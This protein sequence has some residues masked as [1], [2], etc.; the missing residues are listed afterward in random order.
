MALA[1]ELDQWSRRGMRLSL[2]ELAVRPPPK[3]FQLETFVKVVAVVVIAVWTGALIQALVK[4]DAFRTFWTTEEVKE[5][6]VWEYIVVGSG[7]AGS[8]VAGRLASAGRSV[9]L[10]EAGDEPAFISQ[11][12]GIALALAGSD[13]DWAY[14]TLP[15]TKSCLGLDGE[16]C[17]FVRGKALGGSTSI[18]Q[19]MYTRGNQKDFDFNLTG[20]TWQDMKPYILRSQRLKPPPYLPK[21]SLPHHNI[22]G[23][24]PIEYFSDSGNPWHPRV[25]QGFRS[26]NFPQNPDM[27]AESQIGVSQIPGYVSNGERVTAARAY[28]TGK[29]VQKNLKVLKNAQCLKIIIDKN[30]VARGVTVLYKQKKVFNVFAKSEVILSA[31]AI[32]T[33]HILML[34]GVGP[35]RHL[36]QF[37]IPVKSDLPVGQDMSDH[38]MSL[39]LIKVDHGA[40]N[41]G[42]ILNLAKKGLDAVQWLL[43]KSGPLAT[44]GLGDITTFVNTTCYDFDRKQLRNSS[45]CEVPTMQTIMSYVDRGIINLSKH[46]FDRVTPFNTH[47]WKQVFDANDNSGLMVASPVILRPRSRGY[48]QL[49]SADPLTPPTIFPNYLHEDEDVAELVRAMKIIRDLAETPVY[50]EHEASFLKLEFPGC[51]AYD[52]E[53]YWECYVRHMT[54]SIHHAV[55]TAALGTVVDDRLRVRGVRGLRVADAS[56]LPLLPRGNTAAA[57]VAVGERLADFLLFNS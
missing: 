1:N 35:K 53:G 44:V 50:K 8:A 54:L 39:A 18:N 28:L 7:A 34:S 41:A 56:V 43:T 24:I 15:N 27:N 40:S 55:G 21:T 49:T 36:E 10:V 31:G 33:P 26:L 45:A 38:A 17:R 48:V 3:N 22:S 5:G 30:N 19:M 42:G 57:V 37:N 51:P 46:I 20:W 9:L 2:P 29:T 4:R 52:A 12:P 11:I 13:M 25:I 47:I 16:Y 6:S 14:K 23:A 32:G